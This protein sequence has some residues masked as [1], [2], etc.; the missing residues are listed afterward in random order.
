MSFFAYS[1][2][3]RG[4]F[5]PTPNSPTVL[6]SSI[7]YDEIIQRGCVFEADLIDWCKQFCRSDG[8]FI[9]AGA[10]TGTYATSLAP[11]CQQVHAFEPQRCTYYA[12]GGS[13]ALSGLRN[14]HCHNV[15]LGNSTQA[16]IGKATLSI[17]SCDGGGSTI[18]SPGTQSVLNTEIVSVKTLDSFAPDIQGPITLIKLD[19]EGNEPSVLAGA[20][21]LL[22]R[23]L[24]VILYE[25][26]G[27]ARGHP[28]QMP[29]VIAELGYTVKPIRSYPHM[30]LLTIN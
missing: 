28:M 18:M 9:D 2:T 10:H 21:E 14:V 24:P 13:V 22:R 7:F 16:E 25:D 26:N 3:N 27:A 11:Y 30:K 17:V 19:V 12:L 20:S 1:P 23:D 8:V 29:Q 6:L 4:V 5:F 15:A